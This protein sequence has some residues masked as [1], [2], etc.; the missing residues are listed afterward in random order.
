MKRL[1]TEEFIRKAKK[2]HRDVYDYSATEYKTAKEKVKIICLEHGVFEQLPYNHLLGKGCSKCKGGAR[3]NTMDFIFHAKKKHGDKYDYSKVKYEDSYKKVK[4]ICPVHGVFEQKPYHHLQGSGCPKCSG[5]IKKDTTR[6]IEESEQIHENR[7]RYDMAVYVNNHT[8]VKIIC[9]EHG[10]FEQLPSNHL[11]KKQGCIICAG[12]NRKTLKSFIEDA[13]KKHGLKYDYSNSEYINRTKKI[14]I[15]CP[16]HGSFWQSPCDHI[17][18]GGCPRCAHRVSKSEQEIFDFI[19][20]LMKCEQSVRSVISPKELDI[21]IPFLKIGIELNGIY[22]HSDKYLDKNYHLDKLKDCERK[23][24]RLIQIF[25]DE[26][27][28]KKEIVKSRL[29][30]LIGKTP[31]KIYARKCEIKEVDSTTAGKFLD[32]NHI[33][34]KLGSKIKLGLYFENE[35]VSLM[36]FGGLRKNLGQTAKEG[37]Y[38]LLRF[39][40]KLNTN[41][42]GG[43]SKLLKHFEKTYRPKEIISYADRR[44]SNGNLYK[45]LGF[46]HVSDS[47]PNYFYVNRD[48]RENRFKY[49]KSELVKQGFDP[50]KTERQ[51][52]EDLGYSRVYDC[53]TMKFYKSYL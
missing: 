27:L 22:W 49:R 42:V 8:K 37:S 16:T 51:I 52:M 14:E 9:P 30:N 13:I 10:V 41:V 45:Q 19:S 26:W 21:Y 43:A 20:E 24:I 11:T 17:V 48:V 39:C 7:Y 38:E 18:G 31:N 23:G 32:E 6:F 53:G 40:N 35:L 28:Y 2:V 46:E 44:W 1:V 29:L 25:E 3:H 4:I 36:T 33:Q 15:I 50:N 34:G 5:C 12:V 47:Q